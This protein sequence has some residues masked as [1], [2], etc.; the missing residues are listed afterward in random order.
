MTLHERL[1]ASTHVHQQAKVQRN[2]C[3]LGEE[4]DLLRRAILEYFEV[5]LIEIH[6]QFA[7]AV[8]YCEPDIDQLDVHTNRVLGG[9]GDCQEAD[10]RKDA[11]LHIGNTLDGAAADAVIYNTAKHRDES[12]CGTH[13]C[14]RHGYL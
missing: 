4:R 3:A 1:L 5:V 8:A 11:E 2:V 14:V 6:H 12:R 10:I 7:S 9:D 13:E